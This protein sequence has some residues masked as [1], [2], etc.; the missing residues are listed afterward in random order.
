MGCYEEKLHFFQNDWASLLENVLCRQVKLIEGA[1]IHY[2][3]TFVMELVV[4]F[5][6]FFD[7]K[8]TETPLF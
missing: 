8:R 2:K 1:R 5:L 6:Y 4:I 7:T 3:I